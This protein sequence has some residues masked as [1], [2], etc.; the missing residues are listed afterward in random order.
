MDAHDHGRQAGDAQIVRH[1][2][3]PVVRDTVEGDRNGGPPD[4]L[5]HPDEP[6]NR[7]P[8]MRTPAS[9]DDEQLRRLLQAA[10]LVERGRVRRVSS[11]LTPILGQGLDQLVERPIAKQWRACF[12]RHR[13][14][15]TVDDQIRT[16]HSHGQE[17][18]LRPARIDPNDLGVGSIVADALGVEQP[19]GEP[20]RRYEHGAAER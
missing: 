15:V 10:E 16:L 9:E 1:G 8:A 13:A 20:P 6:R 12:Q 17:V 2:I 14:P 19:P 4:V 5:Q 7:L 11:R 18:L 3:R